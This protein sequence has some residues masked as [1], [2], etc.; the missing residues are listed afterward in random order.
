MTTTRSIGW[1]HKLRRR[2]QLDFID[3]RKAYVHAVARMILCV[4]L[5][6]YDRDVGTCC[7]LNKAMY[8]TSDAAHNSES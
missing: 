5:F 6:E 7:R 1:D 2:M 8:G 3:V 4:Q